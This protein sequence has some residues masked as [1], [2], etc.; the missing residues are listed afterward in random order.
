MSTGNIDGTISKRP[1]GRSPALATSGMTILRVGS[2]HSDE[3]IY[4]DLV[5]YPM[6]ELE[7]QDRPTGREFPERFGLRLVRKS[8]TRMYSG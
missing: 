5:D 7:A 2:E 3:A 6:S 4:G 1:W 8:V